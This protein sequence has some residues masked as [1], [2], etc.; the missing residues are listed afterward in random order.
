MLKGLVCFSLYGF[1]QRYGVGILTNA[2]ELPEYY[3]GWRMRVYLQEGHYLKRPLQEFPHVE[4]IEKPRGEGITGMFWRFEG[5]GEA[6][7]VIFRDADS[8]F[9]RREVAAVEEWLQGPDRFHAM[10]DH[11]HHAGTPVMG[12]MWGVKGPFPE[13]LP[14]MEEYLKAHP[15]PTYGDDQAFLARAIPTNEVL[16]HSSVGGGKEFPTVLVDRTRVG[17]YAEMTIHE[18]V[19][20]AYVICPTINQRRWEDLG[21]NLKGS[22]FF[23]GVE[24][25][26]VQWPGPGEVWEPTHPNMEWSIPHFWRATLS[27]LCALN[28]AWVSGAPFVM[29]LEDDIQVEP[30]C[31][32][33]LEK[34]WRALQHEEGWLGLQLS[35]EVHFPRPVVRDGLRRAPGLCSSYGYIWSRKGIEALLGQ[36]WK[37]WTNHVIDAAAAHLQAATDKVFTPD[38]WV[39]K[40]PTPRA[41][42]DEPAPVIPQ[43]E[44]DKWLKQHAHIPD[45]QP[46][47]I[48]ISG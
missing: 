33:E 29:I 6:C 7:P 10:N 12:G 31:D 13:L 19:T 16:R 15:T 45:G 43:E 48:L 34:A 18:A 27:H 25:E 1:D 2:R 24:L 40:T 14:Q 41:K 42:V 38:R 37:S 17:D 20:K 4:V 26:R 21:H 8:R 9:S 5:A 32:E 46:R 36:M 11:P 28:K 44:V 39:L 30:W 47:G 3:P 23:S 35:S 22:R